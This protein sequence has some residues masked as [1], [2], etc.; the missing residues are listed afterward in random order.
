MEGQGLAEWRDGCEVEGLGASAASCMGHL[1]VPAG[2]HQRRCLTG[3]GQLPI[4]TQPARG[5]QWVLCYRLV[6]TGRK[7]LRGMQQTGSPACPPA[8]CLPTQ[9]LS[10]S[11]IPV[12]HA[13]WHS[14][15]PSC[16]L[17]PRLQRLGEPNL[18]RQ[19]GWEAATQEYLP[20]PATE[21][22]PPACAC[23]HGQ[24]TPLR[25]QAARLCISVSCCAGS[26]EAFQRHQLQAR[27]AGRR[28][29]VATG[30]Q[31]PCGSGAEVALATLPQRWSRHAD[32]A[33]WRPPSNLVPGMERGRDGQ[34]VQALSVPP[35]RKEMR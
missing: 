1:W 10:C 21:E 13:R 15:L 8:G 23:I 6:S 9:V 28:H 14:T 20:E 24:H 31:G 4:V 30:T 32:G 3:A 29:Y 5:G 11:A 26:A 18:V 35:L 22:P 17:H 25:D 2:W 16:A 7:T 33:C 19:T 27:P 34:E 12:H